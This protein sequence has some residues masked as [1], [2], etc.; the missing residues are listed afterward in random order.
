LA[1]AGTY[2]SLRRVRLWVVHA[3][4]RP[5]GETKM[6]AELEHLLRTYSDNEVISEQGSL[7][8]LLI[9]LRNLADELQL[10]LE[11]AL[12]ESADVHRERLLQ[13]FDPCL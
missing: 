13:A 11:E 10:D 2:T 1:D 3:D 9:C 7:R 8:D 12:T 6:E 4:E 5:E